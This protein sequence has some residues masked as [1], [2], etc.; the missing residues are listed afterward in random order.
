MTNGIEISAS[1]R[2]GCVAINGGVVDI[3]VTNVVCGPGHGIRYCN[4]YIL[5]IIISQ[6]KLTPY[7]YFRCIGSLGEKDHHDTVEQNGSGYAKEIT[8]EDIALVNVEKS[9]I[10][11]QH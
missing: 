3:I 8:F 2:D 7:M 1:S 10:I 11:D 5:M 6:I 9:I 4:L